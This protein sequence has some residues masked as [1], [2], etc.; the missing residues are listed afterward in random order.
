[1]STSSTSKS[2]TSKSTTSKS[3]KSV[4]SDRLSAVDFDKLL[5]A[6]RKDSQRAE[7]KIQ[8]AFMASWH[9]IACSHSC[10][11]LSFLWDVL[12]ET[13]S[14]Y[15]TQVSLAMRALAGMAK[16]MKS[17]QKWERTGR[18]PLSYEESVWILHLE[19]EDM[20]VLKERATW[21]YHFRAIQVKPT[22]SAFTW[23]ET[24]LFIKRVNLANKQGR[25]PEKDLTKYKELLGEIERISA[26]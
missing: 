4:K 14:P 19:D 21:K 13:K 20:R 9:D 6:I 25:I 7:T 5:S 17:G 2:T 1:M 15:R 16:P 22:K 26:R 23:K 24:A 8:D 18:A 11:R 3:V 10:E 12:T